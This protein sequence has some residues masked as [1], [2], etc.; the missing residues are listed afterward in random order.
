MRVLPRLPHVS[1]Q[2]VVG[3]TVLISEKVLLII[4][5]VSDR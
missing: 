1:L 2:D 5:L 4:A 3:E